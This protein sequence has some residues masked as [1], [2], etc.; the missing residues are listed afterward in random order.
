[1]IILGLLF[2]AMVLFLIGAFPTRWPWKHVNPV[3]LGMFFVCV[4]VTDRF[5]PFT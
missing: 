1:M 2:V 4:A 5:F 3:A